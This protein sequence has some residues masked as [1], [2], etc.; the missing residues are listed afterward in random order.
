MLARKPARHQGAR[1]GGGPRDDLDL[2]PC[3]E[4]RVHELLAGVAHPGHAG[5][6]DE[7]DALPRLEALEHRGHAGSDHILVAALKPRAQL[8]SRQQ[9]ARDAG[10]LAQHDVGA[11]EHVDHARG[12]VLQVAYG[13]TDDGEQA[14]HQT[15]IPRS[16]LE[17]ATRAS[18]LVRSPEVFQVLKNH[19]GHAA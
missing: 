13:R 8:E 10:I 18:Q 7:R 9:L 3:V 11:A 17:S 4:R 15:I 2:K 12:R 16:K 14:R 5:V 19:A 1:D 6:R